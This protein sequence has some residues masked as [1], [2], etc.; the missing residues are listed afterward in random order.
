MSL[1][2]RRGGTLHLPL[3]SVVIGRV[4]GGLVRGYLNAEEEREC[5]CNLKDWLKK[6][7]TSQ[8]GKERKKKVEG[9]LVI[10]RRGMCRGGK[11]ETG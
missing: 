4:T 5:L 6:R 7:E 8:W 3:R 2:S 11:V 1:F 9:D 10:V